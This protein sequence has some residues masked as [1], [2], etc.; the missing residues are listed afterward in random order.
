M[1]LR[2]DLTVAAVVERDGRFLLVEERVG[3][4]LVFNQPA[5]HVERGEQLV[6]AV[7]RETLEETAWTFHPEALLGVYFWDIPEKQRS[8]L[9]FAFIGSVT[10]HDPR[11]RLDRG[12]E[13]ALWASH[14]QIMQYGSRL[15]SPMV[16]RCVEDYLSGQRYSLALVHEF[17]RENAHAL[18]PIVK[19]IS[20]RPVDAQG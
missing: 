13:R 17:V 3:T 9:R 12:I 11:R 18:D 4:G 7:A 1:S 10:H 2:P 19:P 16:L 20:A 8:F 15:R 5:G 6:A 14:E